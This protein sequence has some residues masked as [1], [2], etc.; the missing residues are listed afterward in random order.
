M[1]YTN[2]PQPAI[3]LA[4]LVGL[5]KV[6]LLSE[7]ARIS[8]NNVVKR[9]DA[10]LEKRDPLEASIGIIQAREPDVPIIRDEPGIA[11]RQLDV[12]NERDPEAEDIEDR[13]CAFVAI[14][15]RDKEVARDSDSA[16]LALEAS[17]DPDA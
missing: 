6:S 14:C 7:L 1:A 15:R 10:I 17:T 11:A 9:D 3:D 2:D 4:V 8:A 12:L 13:S 16:I 5:N